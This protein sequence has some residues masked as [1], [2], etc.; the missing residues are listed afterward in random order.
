MKNN[1]FIVFALV[2]LV[3]AGIGG[4]VY[5]NNN[6]EVD[7]HPTQDEWLK[8][9]ISHNIYKSTDL[10]RQRV[11]VNVDIIGQDDDSEPLIPK[12]L[13]ITMSSANGQ[14]VITEGIRKDLYVQIAE[15]NA[16]SILEDYGV[17]KEYKLTVQFID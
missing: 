13:V 17:E 2:L 12:E 8:A 15:S 14:E 10:M 9:Y 1:S 3:I 7:K 4:F 16:K 11:A 6:I 5:W